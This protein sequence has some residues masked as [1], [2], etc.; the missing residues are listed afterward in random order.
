MSGVILNSFIP[1]MIVAMAWVFLRE[2]LS[3]LR[4]AGVLV[5]LSGVLTII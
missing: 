3:P 1:V 4:L 5:S 2:R